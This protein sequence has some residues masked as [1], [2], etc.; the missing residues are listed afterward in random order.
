MVADAGAT[1]RFVYDDVDYGTKGTDWFSVA[2]AE[3]MGLYDKAPWY[4]C[5]AAVTKVVFDESFADYRPTRCISWFL[6]FKQLASIESIG[7]LDTSAATSFACMFHGCSSLTSLDLSGFDT[8]GVTDVN[9]M[10]YCCSSLTKQKK[11]GR[12]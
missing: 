3:K 5:A 1:L 10:F 2:E 6:G 11:G 7:N 9:L 8:A 12:R 4:G